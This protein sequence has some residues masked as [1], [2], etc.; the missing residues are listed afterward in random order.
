M[1]L[2]ALG[3][4]LLCGGLAMALQE[5]HL[6]AIVMGAVAAN[7]ARHHDVPFHAIEGIELPLQQRPQS[8]QK[9]RLLTKEDGDVPAEELPNAMLHHISIPV[10]DPY[11]VARVPAKASNGQFFEFPVTPGT[12]R[13]NFGDDHGSALEIIPSRPGVAARTRRGGCRAC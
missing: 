6:I 9:D 13:V 12:Y 2:E 8:P 1:L 11:R 4:V 3:I 7:F 5:S 10:C